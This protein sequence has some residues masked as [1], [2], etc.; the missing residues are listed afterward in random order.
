ML[1]HANAKHEGQNM[2][3]CNQ[4]EKVGADS[5]GDVNDTNVWREG[6]DGDVLVGGLGGST[7]SRPQAG[8]WVVRK[9]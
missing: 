1:T 5:V 9:T 3:R 4:G 8:E 7:A 6:R 2:R